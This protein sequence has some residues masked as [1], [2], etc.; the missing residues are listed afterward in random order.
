MRNVIFDANII[1]DGER[2]TLDSTDLN[3]ILNEVPNNQDSQII[4]NFLKKKIAQK[5]NKIPSNEESAV[6]AAQRLAKMTA[7]EVFPDTDISE[8]MK[9]NTSEKPKTK[10]IIEVGIDTV[11][12][13]YTAKVLLQIVE[14]Y[15]NKFGKL[16]LAECKEDGKHKLKFF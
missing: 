3:W 16:I 8:L 5:H 11:P 4:K 9:R 14:N 15:C 2:I 10:I 13:E 7:S 12:S 6:Q 1:F